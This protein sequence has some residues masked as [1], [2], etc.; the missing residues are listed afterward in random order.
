VFCACELMLLFPVV[1]CL[2]T[3]AHKLNLGW[4]ETEVKD[5]VIRD[6]CV[7]DGTFVF[8]SQFQPG[9][10]RQYQRFQVKAAL[11]SRG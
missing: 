11:V 9:D 2:V 8:S 10:K 1:S 3:A 4:L 6:T 7:C 5:A